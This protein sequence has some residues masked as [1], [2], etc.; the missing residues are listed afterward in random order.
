MDILDCSIEEKSK[1]GVDMPLKKPG[2]DEVLCH[3]AEGDKEPRDMFLTLLG[4]E[5]GDTVRAL[6]KL[7]ARLDRKKDNHTSSN[8]EIERDRIADSKLLASLTVG[9]LVFM[10]GKW[11]KV[12]TGNAYDVYYAVRPFRNQALGFAL[13][14]SN[15]TKG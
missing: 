8:D 2:T 7:K 14:E 9:G 10:A 15:F 1:S 3:Q 13:D 4:P 6:E 11:V 5:S 12:T